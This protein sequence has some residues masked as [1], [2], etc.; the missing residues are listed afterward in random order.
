MLNSLSARSDGPLGKI[1]PPRWPQQGGQIIRNCTDLRTGFA[2]TVSVIVIGVCLGD[3]HSCQAWHARIPSKQTPHVNNYV[4]RPRNPKGHPILLQE[5]GI[6][7]TSAPPVNSPKG[8]RA[9]VALIHFLQPSSPAFP[10]FAQSSTRP[11]LNFQRRPTFTATM[12]QPSTMCCLHHARNPMAR[13]TRNRCPV[14]GH[15]RNWVP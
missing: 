13:A 11:F 15:H 9:V 3:G 1:C 7:V 10:T 12:Q 14:G 8:R 6:G 5:D 2:I 4:W